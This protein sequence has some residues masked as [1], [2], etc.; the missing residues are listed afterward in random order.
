MANLSNINNKFLVTTGGNILI[1][2]TAANNAIVGAQIMSTG[3]INSTVSGDTVARFNR[4]SND[5]EIIRFQQATSTDGAINSLSGRIAIGSGNTGIFFDSIREVVSGH[6]MT[7]NSYS[8]NIDLGRSAIP[9]K[10]LYLSGTATGTT[11]RFDTLNNNANSANII[12]RSGTD[13]IVGGGSPPNKIYVQDGGNVGIG[14]S[15]PDAKLAIGPEDG[16]NEL[17]FFS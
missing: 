17:R 13:T 11:A 2:K 14:T 4:L 9:F 7:T 1:G 12:Y 15:S 5:G 8:T 6:D 16:T 3:D 10:D